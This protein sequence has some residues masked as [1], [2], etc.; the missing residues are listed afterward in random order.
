[1]CNLHTIFNIVILLL[2]IFDQI[3][4]KALKIIGISLLSIIVLII[5]VFQIF[6]AVKAK[7][8]KELYARLGEEALVIEVEG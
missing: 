2:N 1:M 7:Q 4:K 6:V 8:A 3:M 5:L